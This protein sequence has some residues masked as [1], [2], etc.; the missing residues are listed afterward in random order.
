[1][2][3]LVKDGIVNDEGLVEQGDLIVVDN[4]YHFLVMQ[5]GP[6]EL[7][8]FSLYNDLGNRLTDSSFDH[9][10]P[11]KEVIDI[12][13]TSYYSNFSNFRLIKKKNYKIELEY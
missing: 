5:V 3:V 13:K 9:R 2:K 8:L 1:M 11:F 12:L 6:D 4:Q 7:K 10:T